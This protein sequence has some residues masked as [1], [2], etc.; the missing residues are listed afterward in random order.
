MQDETQK[1]TN[2]VAP[3][4]TAS[5]QAEMPDILVQP[6]HINRPGIIVLQWLTYAF[7]GWAI[8]A[9]A[10]LISATFTTFIIGYDTST[11]TS[12]ALAAILVLL[13]IALVCDFFYTKNEPDKKTGASM[14]V[15]VIH[16][17]LFAL[18]AIAALI[19]AVFSIVNLIITSNDTRPYQVALYSAGLVTIVYIAT[20]VRTINPPAFFNIT[21]KYYKIFM[22]VFAT[23][24]IIASI[25]GPIGYAQQTKNDKLIE[26]NLYTIQSEISGY[27]RKNKALPENLNQLSLQKDA[28]VLIEKNLV[29][30]KSKGVRNR[31]GTR[32]TS[33]IYSYELCVTY[34]KASPDYQQG[35]DKKPA[36][37]STLDSDINEDYRSGSDSLYD[38]HPAGEK[39]YSQEF[40]GN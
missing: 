38:P 27:T 18:L 5:M 36:S 25:I 4:N 19:A 31:T 6:E 35:D 37:S 11:L 9:L 8:L 30:Y 20:F 26:E 34:K 2:N 7:W 15:M 17:V 14:V 33:K 12:Y 40:Y 10:V 22:L 29:A 21:S 32:T 28:K 16:A 1:K 3:D 39:C 24:V 13:P 23:L